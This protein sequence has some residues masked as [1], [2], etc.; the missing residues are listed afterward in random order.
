M[1]I[2]TE[3]HIIARGKGRIFLKGFLNYTIKLIEEG[4]EGLLSIYIL[5]INKNSYY[6]L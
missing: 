5:I 3:G 2:I 6:I 4:A 1:Q